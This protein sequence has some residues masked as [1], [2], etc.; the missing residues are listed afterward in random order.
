MIEH[1]E[2]WAAIVF[3][4]FA[5]LEMRYKLSKLGKKIEEI[6]EVVVITK[7]AKLKH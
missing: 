4:F 1:E 3:I 2:I 7:T 5:Q 6:R